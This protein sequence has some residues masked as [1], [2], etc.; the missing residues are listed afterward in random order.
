M[1]IVMK[2]PQKTPKKT[3]KK[4]L[5]KAP[6]TQNERDRTS[7]KRAAETKKKRDRPAKKRVENTQKYWDEQLHNH[8]LGIHRAAPKWRVL[9]CQF[10]NKE[11]EAVP[12]TNF[13]VRERVVEQT[14]PSNYVRTE[15]NTDQNDVLPD[16]WLKSLE[17][18]FIIAELKSPKDHGANLKKLML[19]DAWSRHGEQPI[20]FSC[21]GTPAE[22]RALCEQ[23]LVEIQLEFPI[24]KIIG[25]PLSPDK[26]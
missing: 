2:T 14:D 26:Q 1:L 6:Q 11:G 22:F 10:V 25:Y 20:D 4:A 24:I 17:Y 8:R 15:A 19:E 23:S 9:G 21:V 3:R 5:K 18:L 12:L 13:R 16:S 7:K